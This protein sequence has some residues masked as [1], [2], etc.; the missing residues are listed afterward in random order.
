MQSK[1]AGTPTRIRLKDP[2]NGLSHAA[3]LVAATVGTLLL[4]LASPSNAAST[5]MVA[6]YGLSLMALYAAS[7]AYHLIPARQPY[8]KLLRKLDHCAI[9]LLIAG[10]YT[11]VLWWSLQGTRRMIF[12]GVVW[13]LAAAGIV[14]RIAW[15]GAPRWLYTG[16]YLGLGWIGVLQAGAIR[17]SLPHSVLLFIVLGGLTYTAG[18]VIYA[19]KRPNLYPDRFGFHGLWHLFVLAASA[20]HF[21]GVWA[22][23]A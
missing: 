1:A 10:T 11:P 15:L 18:A 3:G 17:Q 9:F 8:D 13:G 12:L 6:I 23:I 21:A 16:M 22:L 19:L 20:F 2:F 7:S 5:A 14:M 4:V